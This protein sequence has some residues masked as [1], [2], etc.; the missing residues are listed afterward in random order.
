MKTSF[1]GRAFQ[2]WE[3]K[4]S[5]GS[6]LVRSPKGSGVAKNVDVMFAGVEYFDLPRH[7]P[8]LQLDDATDADVALAEQKLG[9][10]VESKDVYVLR[11]KER[12]HLVVAAGIKVQESDLDIFESP[13]S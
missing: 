1:P 7:L 3:Y 2:C 9:K 8:E 5:H 10:K 11:V 13:F 12:R 6:L 4:V